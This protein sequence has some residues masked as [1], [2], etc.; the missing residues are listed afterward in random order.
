MLGSATTA[1]KGGVY[2]TVILSSLTVLW[3]ALSFPTLGK[4]ERHFLQQDSRFDLLALVDLT[5]LND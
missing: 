2:E 4:T 3:H 5:H 1:T